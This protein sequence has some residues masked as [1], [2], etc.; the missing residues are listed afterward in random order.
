MEKILWE[1][2]ENEK[3]CNPEKLLFLDIVRNTENTVN[4]R[5]MCC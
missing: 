3:E 5:I 4:Y 1:N 2:Q